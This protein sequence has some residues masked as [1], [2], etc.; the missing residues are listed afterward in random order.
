MLL[1]LALLGPGGFVFGQPVTWEIDPEHFSIVFEADH[2]GYQSQL[3]LFLEGSGEFDFDPKTFEFFSGRV[4][5]QA[6]SV[7]SNN[8]DRDDHLR[9]RDFLNSRRHPTIL[10]E[11]GEFFP[12]QQRSGGELRGNLTLLGR[13][14]PIILDVKL[15]KFAKY[16]FGHR[17]E[18][19]GISANTV[20]DR[21]IWGM[22]YGVSNDM[23]GNKVIL[24]FEFEAVQE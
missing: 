6:G 18:T 9:G 17:K 21:S 23:V 7:F 5:I 1:S 11:A 12:N 20:I 2:I 8:D 3:G 14:H 16:P 24:R 15:N 22:D 13:T 10:F 19:I 4:E